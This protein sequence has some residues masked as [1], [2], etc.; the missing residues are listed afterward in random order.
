MKQITNL[1][2]L[3]SSTGR[4][5]SAQPKACDII[6]KP[7]AELHVFRI[8]QHA[9]VQYVRRGQIETSL[10]A[11][12][13]LDVKNLSAVH[14]A[15]YANALI[16]CRLLVRALQ[17]PDIWW[18][19]QDRSLKPVSVLVREAGVYHLSLSVATEEISRTRFGGQMR[20]YFCETVVLGLAQLLADDTVSVYQVAML[21]C[22]YAYFFE[23]SN[24]DTPLIGSP[25]GGTLLRLLRNDFY[26]ELDRTMENSKL[27]LRRLW[28]WIADAYSGIYVVPQVMSFN[29][30]CKG[31]IVEF[32]LDTVSTFLVG[33]PRTRVVALIRSRMMRG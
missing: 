28:K 16:Y 22:L 10:I 5:C 3:M 31:D 17:Q 23:P 2:V 11:M 27:C 18:M 8:V 32:M 13:C 6:E 20:Q 1:Y 25:R 24:Y 19:S 4:P 30:I 7:S 14:R 12:E 15:R 26:N 33:T 21:D 9:Q 29:Q